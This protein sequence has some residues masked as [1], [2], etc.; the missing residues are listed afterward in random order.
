MC[1]EIFEPAATSNGPNVFHSPSATCWSANVSVFCSPPV[2]AE[3]HEP[4]A[5][6]VAAC[7][8][9]SVVWFGAW[10]SAHSC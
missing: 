4:S 3:R 5:S 6:S 7:H 10:H 8:V 1:T 2:V 9:F